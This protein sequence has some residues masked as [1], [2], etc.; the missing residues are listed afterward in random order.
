MPLI[1]IVEAMGQI[2]TI[3]TRIDKK[4]QLIAAYLLR[5]ER[6]KDPLTREGGTVAVLQR[7]LQSIRVLEERKIVIRRGVQRANE[8]AEVA[9]GGQMRTI[10]DW[11]VWR[12]EVVPRLS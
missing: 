9:V 6:L 7:E 12:R 10:A 5:P 8:R 2:H 1:T 4:Q 3:D 11:L